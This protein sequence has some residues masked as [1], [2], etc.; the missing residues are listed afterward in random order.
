[1]IASSRPIAVP[2]RMRDLASTPLE[3][4]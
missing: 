2:V 3:E 4:L 1:V